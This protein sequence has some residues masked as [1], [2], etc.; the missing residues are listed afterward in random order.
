MNYDSIAKKR[1]KNSKFNPNQYKE[2]RQVLNV[3]AQ[4]AN[5]RVRQLMESNTESPAL[6]RAYNRMR[7][8]D[9]EAFDADETGGILFNVMNKTGWLNLQHEAA[10]IREFL[11][12]A[13]SHV[14][15]ASYE[16]KA[17]NAHMKHGLS[18]HN[19]ADNMTGIDN[20]RFR[21]YDQDRI[22]FAL[23]IYR[24]I[25][26]SGGA[27]AIYG[28]NGKGGFGSDNLFNLI[29][30]EIEGYFPG[31]SD[32]ARESM[33]S[34]VIASGQAALEDFR[35]NEMYGFLKGSPKSRKRDQNV[36][37]EMAKATSGREF[38]NRNKWIKKLKW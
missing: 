19:Q 27:T 32:T 16:T 37:S 30:D 14:P 11:G 28:N 6:V 13:T 17:M 1:E 23:E 33:M 8:K 35:H 4:E 24:R 38:F 12:D 10:R 7:K 36:L 31:M 2:L 25:E 21:G 15:V 29:F 9:R 22:K 34:K 20:V 3:Y 26:D 5:E 18:F